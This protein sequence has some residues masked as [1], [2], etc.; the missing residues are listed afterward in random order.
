M[1]TLY[2]RDLITTQD[3]SVDEL[4]ETME[5]AE[6]F[7][8]IMRGGKRPPK[9]LERKNFFMVFYAPSTRTRGAFEAGMGLLGGHA[10]YIDVTTTRIRAGEALKDIAKMYDIYGDGIGVRILDDAIDF[11]YGEGRKVVEQFAEAARVPVI[12]MACCTYHP[13]QAIGD[14]M[15]VKNKIGSLRGKKYVIMWAYSSKLRGRCSIHSEVLIATRFGMD[16]VLAHPPGFDIDPKIVE[17]AKTN[18]RE[19]GGSFKISHDFEEALKGANVVFPRSWVTSE[20]LKVGATA[21]GADKEIEMYNNCRNWRLEQKHVNDLMGKPAIVT[22]VLPVFRGQEATNEVM[23]G[24]NS[25]IYEQAENNLYAK[26][27]VLSLTMA[28]EP[29]L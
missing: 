25:V 29:K 24:P 26:M 12:N 19:S 28:E 4:I 7:K 23:D 15:T 11:I 21:F 17:A 5:L 22:H 27:A 14:I 13:T 18:A 20:L 16:V 8:K 1:E 2:G 6:R 10:P 9:I 3:W